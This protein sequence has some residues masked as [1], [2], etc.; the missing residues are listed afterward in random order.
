ML[1]LLTSRLDA[2]T[3]ICQRHGVRSLSVFGSA[4]TDDFDPAHS[5]VDLLVEFES[6]DVD[7]FDAYFGL[8]EQLTEL[9]GRPVDLVMPSA[10]RNP[11]FA[12]AVDETRRELYAA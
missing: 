6:P 12:S 10:L 5:D 7:L 4:T 8:R 3:E 1:E 9:F 11:Y 2:I